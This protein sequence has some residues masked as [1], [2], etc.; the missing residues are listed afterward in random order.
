MA[1]TFDLTEEFPS[2]TISTS[3]YW[4]LGIVRLAHPVT[5]SRKNGKSIAVLAGDGAK[6]RNSPLILT[7]ECISL[8]VS[9]S[10]S[11]HI[12]ALSATLKKGQKELLTEILPGDWIFAWIV[13]HEDEGRK[14]LA[15][16]K[17]GEV[18]NKKEDGLKFVGRVGSLFKNLDT[19]STHS[20]TYSLSANG[21]REM[22]S[23]L[24]YDPNLAEADLIRNDIETWMFKVGFNG[25]FI[26]LLKS[27]F[28]D[29]VIEVLTS[30]IEL[31]L[32]KGAPDDQL[33]PTKGS[34][35][36]DQFPSAT[37]GQTTGG[38][39]SPPFAYVVPEMAGKWL[40]RKSRKE[41]SD[42]LAY[43]DILDVLVGV[44]KYEGNSM[45]PTVDSVDGT[46]KKTGKPLMGAIL[47]IQPTFANKPLW[48]IL[49][50]FSNPSVNEI[51]T[52]LKANEKGDIVPTFVARQKPFST[53]A[54][55]QDFTEGAAPSSA[56]SENDL[57]FT[58]F[59]DLPRWKIPRHI[60]RGYTIGRGEGSK[61]NLVEV[62]G[63]AAHVAANMSATEQIV[64]NHPL[65]DSIDIQRSGIYSYIMTAEVT[66]GSQ[67]G[68][69]PGKFMQLIAD[70]SMGNHLALQGQMSLV[71][72]QSPICEGDNIEFDGIVFHIESLTHNCSINGG[73][74]NFST[75][76]TLSNGMI[77]GTVSPIVGEGD[78]PIFP[79]L[80][81]DT[82]EPDNQKDHPEQI[83]L[84]EP[85][86]TSSEEI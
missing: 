60:I 29:N 69:V 54:L 78:F 70:W 16:I 25:L 12:K 81:G 50:Q 53:D 22:E 63:D 72:I 74:K 34:P 47:A 59:T 55:I 19:S 23:Q 82:T 84:A 6:V 68:K 45:Y 83:E 39:D 1:A 4:I 5:Y 31:L 14:L 61:C 15:R 32:G 3:P 86:I 28:D 51:Y 43:A 62:W 33:N 10:K 37:A 30:Y 38:K 76:L 44:Q 42:I 56:I 41:G 75:D 58:K 17:K 49:H 48:G 24:F 67:V 65:V 71:G 20:I 57:P 21:F 35:G 64:E 8:N 66:Q 2:K 9:R 46:V 11:S 26:P 40:G 79:G 13:S 77:P 73:V 7:Q 52:C 36:F 80:P 18:C 27:M 85:G